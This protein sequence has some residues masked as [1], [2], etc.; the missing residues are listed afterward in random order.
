[1]AIEI[2]DSGAVKVIALVTFAADGVLPTVIGR[3]IQTFGGNGGA[4]D[5]V[6]LDPM[7]ADA[8]IFVSPVNISDGRFL[9]VELDA[10]EPGDNG[11]IELRQL[12]VAGA[13]LNDVGTWS[14]L[15]IYPQQ[16]GPVAGTLTGG[17]V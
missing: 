7:P 2:L 9:E 11:E 5:L 6:P 14:V 10:A 4:V 17:P 15:V 8:V 12:D 3:G 1:M 13:A 16:M